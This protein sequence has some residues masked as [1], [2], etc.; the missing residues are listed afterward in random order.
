MLDYAWI[1]PVIPAVSFVLILFF[2]KSMPR[3]GSEIGIA[4]VGASFV[5]SCITAVAVDPT[6]RTTP[7]AAGRGAE[8]VR[9][10]LHGE[11]W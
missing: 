8:G 5:L 2:G 6:G 11:R 4:A 3:H 7:A 10:G 1:I 9:Q